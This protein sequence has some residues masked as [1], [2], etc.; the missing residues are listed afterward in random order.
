[1]LN[2][3]YWSM[4]RSWIP[5][6]WRIRVRGALATSAYRDFRFNRDLGWGGESVQVAHPFSH[7]LAAHAK[8]E[9]QGIDLHGF[10]SR[11]L[12]LGE[13]ARLYARA[14]L[15]SGFPVSLHDV[16]IDIPHA[17]HDRTLAGHFR[18]APEYRRDLIFVNPDHWDDALG[19][20]Y[21]SGGGRDRY[22]I[23]YWFWELERFPD[24]WLPA[25]DSVDEI[26]VSSEFVERAL[27]GVTDK[28]ITRV[29]LP[30][31]LGEDSGLMRHHFGLDEHSYVYFCSFDFNSSIARK[32]PF[33]VIKAFCLAFP[34]GDEKVSLLIKSFNGD[35]DIV[36][37]MQLAAAAA[38]DHRIM[39]RDDM[40]ERSDLQALHRC[41]DV[42]VS[43][44]R[45]EGFGL[46]MAE[47]MCMGKPVV[48]TSYSGNME[49][50]TPDNSCLV[51]FDMV[52][53]REGEYQHGKGQYWAEPDP[54]HAAQH[55]RKLYED[56][57]FGTRIGVKALADMQRRFSAD[58]CMAVLE[59]RLNQLDDACQAPVMGSRVG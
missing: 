16:D 31:V 42:H 51:D 18:L 58:A 10:L 21:G 13:C 25:L 39:L 44:H 54:L 41:V 5:L 19:R 8:A 53:V 26:M 2:H 3:R 12:G 17:R 48:A 38:A 15:E 45:S 56:R 7:R 14:L 4:L 33:A 11:W 6:S 35:R 27:R 36:L 40:L 20:L 52:P 43:L 50:M 30:V 49:Y 23:G 47:A 46:G 29:P 28:P 34:R 37:L 59:Q 32:N 55:M 1:M 22:T 57:A 9:A 24:A